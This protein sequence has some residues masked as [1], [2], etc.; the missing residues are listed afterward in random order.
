M[1]PRWAATGG[2]I[3]VDRGAY[4]AAPPPGG[5]SRLM[6]ERVT[7][8]RLHGRGGQGAVT[9]A[10]LLVAAA[11][12][13]GKWGQAIPSF[14]AE[15]RGA[16]VLAFARV[17]PE[18]VPVHSQVRRPHVVV[19]LDPGL[20][21]VERGRVLRGLRGG[22]TVV[23]NLP[24][25]VD[26][27]GARLFYVDATRIA[28]ELGLVVAGWPVVNT[29]MLG[30]LARATGLVSIDSVVDAIMEFWSGRERVAE[31]N[32]EA[33]RR[34]YRETRPAGAAEAAAE[35]REVAGRG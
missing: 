15:R 1:A 8:I 31:L 33:A 14:G 5:L 30:A 17:S 11:L 9:A 22:G 16:H 35:A 20:M 12:R 13:E 3:A 27:G 34:A 32:A 25:P 7:E 10:T 19:V 6:A 21:L 2:C 29:A 26:V 23:A 24:A 28:K 18:P 4:S